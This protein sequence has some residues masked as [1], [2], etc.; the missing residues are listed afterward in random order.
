[1]KKGIYTWFGIELPIKTRIEAIKRSNFDTVMLN[2]SE[3][4]PEN[5]S[6]E[7]AAVLADQYGLEVENAH[8]SFRDINSMWVDGID[9]DDTMARLDNDITLASK[10]SIKRLIIHASSGF[11]PPPVS[12]IGLRRFGQLIETAHKYN[13]QLAFENLRLSTYNDFIF[14]NFKTDTVGFC[15]D[16]GH[17]N[18]F[19]PN[20]NLLQKHS[21]KLIAIHIHDNDGTADQHLMPFGGTI[22][23]AAEMAQLK[24]TTYKGSFTL[25]VAAESSACCDEALQR[26]SEC[27][28]RLIGIIG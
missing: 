26:A 16:S 12:E 7:E 13:I 9:G 15:Y 20:E 24:Q 14:D 8:L 23:W 11:T 19:M 18:V 5:G 2:W 17:R 4:F 22:D 28:D 3:D 25:E 10:Y 21:D 1:M 27:A 6:R